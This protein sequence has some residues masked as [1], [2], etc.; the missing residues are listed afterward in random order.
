MLKSSKIIHRENFGKFSSKILIEVLDDDFREELEIIFP[1]AQQR[2]R[3]KY[4]A[5]ELKAI[6]SCYENKNLDAT[7]NIALHM[8]DV[9]KAQSI[10]LKELIEYYAR[11]EEFKPYELKIKQLLLF[12]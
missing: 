5:Y 3:R 9:I 7:H 6:I 1:A 10:S 11:C 8:I 12:E 2:G 4:G